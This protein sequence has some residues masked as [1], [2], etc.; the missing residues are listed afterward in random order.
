MSRSSAT[1]RR[2]WS[3]S[4]GISAC[5]RC[6]RCRATASSAVR[7]LSQQP[8]L[9]PAERDLGR[10]ILA[11]RAG[12]ASWPSPWRGSSRAG[13]ASARWRPVSNFPVFWTSLGAD[14]RAAAACLLRRRL[15]ADDRVSAAIDLQ[16]DRRLPGQAGVP[17]ALSG[18]VLLYGLLHRRDR[19]R[20]HH[21][22]QQGTDRSGH[23][24]LGCGTASIL[25]LVVVPQAMRIIIPPLTSQY[26][27]LT[28]NSS[29]AIA[30][31]YP[32]L[33]AIGG[34]VL[35][36]TG[37]AIE[38]VA[39]LDGRLSR[40]QPGDLGVHELVQRQDGAG[41]EVGHAR[42]RP[43]LCP[44]RNGAGATPPRGV[45]RLR[46]LGAQQPVRDDPA[47]PS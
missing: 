21:G 27:N 22:R 43:L 16:P 2:C 6:C 46:R 29:L 25:R 8:R 30:I 38:I 28:K 32:D 11:D 4:S 14:H 18:A 9:F 40:P 24:R 15:S 44:H 34:T 12:L 39:D 35:N 17:V 5:C 37:Q 7:L 42:A 36:Q 31:G 13:R 1:S 19:A 33:V 23:A 3:S 26:L 41:G 47:T 45:T 10:R 20:R